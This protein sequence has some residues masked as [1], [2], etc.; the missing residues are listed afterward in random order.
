MGTRHGAADPVG[1]GLLGRE[2]RPRR[3]R[4]VRCSTARRWS[5]AADALLAALAPPQ[6]RDRGRGRRRPA[7][8]VLRG[9]RLD[10]RPQR[11]D[12]PRRAR[13]RRTPTSRRSR[14]ADT[15][16]LRVEWYLG[17]DDDPAVQEALAATQD[18]IAARRGMR[19]FVVR[20]ADGAPG[21]LH[22]CSPAGGRGR[23]RD[24]PALRDARTRAGTGSAAGWSRPRSPRAG[25]RRRG[26]SPTT[27]ASARALYERLGL[28]DRVAAAT[29]SSR[30]ALA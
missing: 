20:G 22:A 2:L 27:T 17:Y 8:A 3:G 21:R 26:S 23:G 15:R 7:A 30:H 28:R 1:A 6:A 29:R 16:P 4:R 9:R 19:A 18:R 5:R 13:R 25:A 12:G 10:R 14:C 11:D 24:R